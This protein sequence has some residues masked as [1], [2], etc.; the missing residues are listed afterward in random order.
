MF[1][2]GQK[3]SFEPTYLDSEEYY[4]QAQDAKSINEVNAFSPTQ[5]VTS[6]LG[7]YLTGYNNDFSNQNN[8]PYYALNDNQLNVPQQEFIRENSIYNKKTIN[9]VPLKDYYDN[10]TK[11]VLSEGNWF[12]NKEDI[13]NYE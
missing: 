11:K 9:G 3:E 1:L 8:N 10:Y 13:I 7:H 6:Q 2:R 4:K 5:Q 12:L